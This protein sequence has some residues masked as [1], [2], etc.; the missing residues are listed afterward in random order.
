VARPAPR[1][2]IHRLGRE[3]V[4][5][6]QAQIRAERR[7]VGRES[8]AEFRRRAA[9][10]LEVVCGLPGGLAQCRNGRDLVTG[11]ESVLAEFG[12][13]PTERVRWPGWRT[14]IEGSGE[15]TWIRADSGGL[16]DMHTARGAVV[17]GGETICTNANPCKTGRASVEAPFTGLLVGILEDP[18]VY[19]GNPLCH[20]VELDQDTRRVVESLQS[21]GLRNGE[22]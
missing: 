11:V 22:T 4:K 2:R 8:L 15:K 13:L 19:P 10:R 7:L 16:V 18:V 20:L 14:V 9:P 17:R 6:A 21:T 1:N 5:A 3:A 12:L